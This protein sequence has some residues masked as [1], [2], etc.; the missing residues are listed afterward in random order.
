MLWLKS[1]LSLPEQSESG[2]LLERYIDAIYEPF[3]KRELDVEEKLFFTCFF[4]YTFFNF[5]SKIVR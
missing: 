3:W 1:F 2:S 5:I 4:Q